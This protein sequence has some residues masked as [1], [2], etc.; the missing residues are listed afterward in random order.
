LT[1]LTLGESIVAALSAFRL[2]AAVAFNTLRGLN[3]LCPPP[4]NSYR[5]NGPDLH[6]MS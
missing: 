4:E 6:P 2:G 1:V 5:V 3:E